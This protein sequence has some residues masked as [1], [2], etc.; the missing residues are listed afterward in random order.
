MYTIITLFYLSF[1]AMIL[2]VWLKGHEL[3]T[4]RPTVVSRLGR[5]SDHFFITVYLAIRRAVSYVNKHTFIA[6]VQWVAFHI[7]LRVR[8]VYVEIKHRILQNPH[9]KRMIDAVRGRGE[10]KH[11]G[12]SFYLRRIAEGN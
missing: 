6:L 10:I 4:G 1:I 3:R 5:G 7:L 11:H 12:A 2:M 9:G 8:R